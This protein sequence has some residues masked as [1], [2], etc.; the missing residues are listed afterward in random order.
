MSRPTTIG[1]RWLGGATVRAQFQ[2]RRGGTSSV[3]AAVEGEATFNRLCRYGVRLFGARYD[4]D[5]YEEVRPNAFCSQC[6]GWGHIAPHCEAAAPK[7]SIC[8]KDH[9][10]T[11]RRC[12]VEECEV[13]SGRPRPH[14]TTKCA[15]C[16]GPHGAWADA[17]AAEREARGE[18][19]GWRTPPPLRRVRRDAEAPEEPETEA[20]AAQEKARGEAEVEVVEEEGGSGQ[21]AMELGE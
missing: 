11:N 18:A 8:A 16:G 10:E 17:C 15:N 21:A 20:T 2:E 7:S 5:A 9:E 1:N 19:R 6:S 14:G 3:V 13:G 12:P 4:V